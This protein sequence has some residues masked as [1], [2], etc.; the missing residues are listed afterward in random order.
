MLKQEPAAA[1]SSG[2]I[3]I[4]YVQAMNVLGVGRSTLDGW[5]KSGLL[6]FV[7]L[8]NGQ[9][10]IRRDDVDEWLESLAEKW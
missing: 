10:R 4:N 5:R 9:L 2:T 8:P 6:V 1:K 3:W 7:K